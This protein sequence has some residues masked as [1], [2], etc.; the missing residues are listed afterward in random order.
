M[1]FNG[2]APYAV[3]DLYAGTDFTSLNWLE[4]QWVAWYIWIGNPVVAT[5][6]ASF[7]LHEVCSRLKQTVPNGFWFSNAVSQ[8]EPGANFPTLDCLLRSQYSMDYHRCHALLPSVETATKQG[9]YAR[10]TVGV[11]QTGSVLTLHY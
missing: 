4:R 1:A 8:S 3:T 5:G 7:L 10:G 11:H 6:L 2:T 9:P